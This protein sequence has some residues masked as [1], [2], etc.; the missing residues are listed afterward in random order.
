[1]KESKI[2]ECPYCYHIKH[3]I[4]K[5]HEQTFQEALDEMTEENKKMKWVKCSE[6]LPELWTAIIIYIPKI[7]FARHEGVQEGK[8]IELSESK[9]F[10]ESSKNPLINPEDVTYWMHLPEPP[11]DNK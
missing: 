11:K 4:C 3:V 8:R 6:R 10:W 9:W 5:E 7:T 2:S 1:M